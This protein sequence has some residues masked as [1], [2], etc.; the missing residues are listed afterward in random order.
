MRLSN[1]SGLFAIFCFGGAVYSAS[2]SGQGFWF[3]L[4]SGLLFYAI[5]ASLQDVGR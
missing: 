3:F 4:S 1:V 5:S 2:G